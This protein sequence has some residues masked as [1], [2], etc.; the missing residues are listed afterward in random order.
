LEG[1]ANMV[2]P[3]RLDERAAILDD[4]SIRGL[5]TPAITVAGAD[6]T[7]GRGEVVLK[8]KVAARRV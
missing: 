5:M 3:I 1:A 2:R 8:S 6:L 4:R 7:R